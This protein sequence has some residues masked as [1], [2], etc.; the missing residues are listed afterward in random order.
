[1][2]AMSQA[3]DGHCDEQ[4]KVP[5][6]RPSQCV[7]VNI[8]REKPGNSGRRCLFQE[9]GNAL[10]RDHKCLD[11]AFWATEAALLRITEV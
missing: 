4:A 10:S 2:A 8:S 11:L 5:A 3:G 6:C 1:M 7:A 9:V